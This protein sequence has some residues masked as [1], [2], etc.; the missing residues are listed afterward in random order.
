MVRNWP[1]PLLTVVLFAAACAMPATTAST[2][3][4]A[5]PRPMTAPATKSVPSMAAAGETMPP[6]AQNSV[7]FVI[8]GDT[9]TGERAQYDVG[10]QLWKSHQVFPYEFL[11][12]VGDN[13]YGSERPQD[14]ERKFVLPYKPIIAAN[15]PFYASLGNHDD[16]N[17]RWYKYF[18]MNGERYYTFK[19]NSVRF[20]ALDSNYMDREQTAWLE[21][22]LANSDSPW[23]IAFFHHPLFVRWP[24]R[25]GG[26]LASNAGAAVPQEQR[27]RGL[28][29]SRT[30][31]RTPE[32]AKRDLLLHRGGLGETAR[33]RY[34]EN[35]DDR[36]GIRHRLLVRARRGHRR[37]DALPNTDADRQARGQRYPAAARSDAVEVSM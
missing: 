19:K 21:K 32:A 17:Q 35:G 14:Y 30:L 26:R 34:Y 4:T 11:I 1:V 8:L 7:K 33:R 6:V 18:N 29:R 2:D 28:R 12:M 20:F 36:S 22:E 9:G 27:Q 23:K 25:V 24:A 13:M 16:P 5:Q 3:Q 31:L 10:A 37:S 15:I